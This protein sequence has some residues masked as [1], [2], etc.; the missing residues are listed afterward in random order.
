MFVTQRG[1]DAYKR[2]KPELGPMIRSHQIRRNLHNNVSTIKK[3]NVVDERDI[4]KM[5]AHFATPDV[6]PVTEERRYDHDLSILCAVLTMNSG[7]RL[8]DCLNLRHDDLKWRPNEKMLQIPLRLGKSN[9]SGS[10]S[11]CLSFTRDEQC[12]LMC[13]I[14]RLR[15]FQSK[16]GK[17]IRAAKTQWLLPKYGTNERAIPHRITRRWKGWGE[18]LG[19]GEKK[20]F[21]AHSGRNTRAQ[22]AINMGVDPELIASHFNWRSTTTISIYKQNQARS[23]QGVARQMVNLPVE[24][25][26]ARIKHTFEF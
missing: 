12:P 5:V 13:P 19:W 21:S 11:S 22:L 14:L 3:A 26:V 7:G 9:R 16:W 17:M 6:A 20:T 8:M 15:A 24:E 25:R 4:A 2:A 18:Q 1:S 23:D 10:R